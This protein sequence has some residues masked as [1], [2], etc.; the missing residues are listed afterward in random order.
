MA[1]EKKPGLRRAVVALQHRDFRLLYLAGL[2]S[3]TGGMIQTMVSLWQIYELTGSAIH[4]GLTGFARAIPIILFSLAGGVIADR[5]DRRRIIMI[6]QALGGLFAVTLGGLTAMGQIDVWHIYA[7][8]F[9]SSAVTSISTPARTAIIASLVP[10]HHLVNAMALNST[11]WQG[12]RI[13]APSI[14]GAMM[15]TVGFPLTYLITGAAFLLTCLALSFIYLGPIPRRSQRTM[16]QDLVEGLSFV[17]QRSIILALLATDSAAM[18]FGSIQ[19]LLPIIADNLA[20]GTGAEDRSLGPAMFG[21]LTSAEGVGA[22]LGAFVIMYLGDFRYKGF[23]IVGSI[24][25]YCV[26]LVGLALSPWFALTLLMVAGLGI[27]DSFQSTPRNAVIQLIT[28]EELR[29]RV[30]SFQHML[31]V[32]MPSFGQGFMGGAAALLG[33]PLA[34]GLGAAAC[35]SINVGLLVGRKD[36]RARDLGAVPAETASNRSA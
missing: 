25:A 10:Q 26:C 23:F 24:L 18:L 29:G 9:L 8:T 16:V 13:L 11:T 14:A 22:I 15:V 21:L 31:V 7:V 12:T 27:T 28:P 30:S 6:P 36:L 34:L 19:A 33:V 2:V 1:E 4:L 17:R 35:A 5:F 20:G 3:A 32:G